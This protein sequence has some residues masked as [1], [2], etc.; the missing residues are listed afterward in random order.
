MKHGKL[1]VN[2]DMTDYHICL[3]R[4]ALAL[5]RELHDITGGRNYS[6]LNKRDPKKPMI[7]TLLVTLERMGS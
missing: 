1:T 4:Q 3:F 6:F 2:P 7:N 5:L